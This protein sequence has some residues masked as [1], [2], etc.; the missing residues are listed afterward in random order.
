MS[1]DHRAHPLR[2]LARIERQIAEAESF[3]VDAIDDKV[4]LRASER[5]AE[6]SRMLADVE[7][8]LNSD[9]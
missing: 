8:K 4:P 5:L 3:T 2:I 6:L 7:R 1:N 9:A